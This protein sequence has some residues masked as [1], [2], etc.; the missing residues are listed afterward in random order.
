MFYEIGDYDTVL[1]TLSQVEY[2]NTQYSLGAR[3]LLLRTYYE[4]EEITSF[5]SLCDA[6]RQFLHRN[7][8]LSEIKRK[9]NEQTIKLVRK[10]FQLKLEAPFQNRIKTQK[11]V[12]NLQEEIKDATILFNKEWLG[13]KVREILIP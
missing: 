5:F 10:A 11:E 1:G 4:L 6:F 8:L 9:G 2:T 12:Q 13:Q 3:W 7:Q